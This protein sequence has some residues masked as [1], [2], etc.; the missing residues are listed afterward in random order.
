MVILL[1]SAGISEILWM[2]QFLLANSFLKIMDNTSHN[3]NILKGY[4]MLFYFA[5]SMI[6]HEPSEEC[7]VDFW[8]KGILKNLP[9]SSANPNFVKAAS[10][11]RDSFKDKI[12]FGKLLHEDFLR[13]F[14][15][16]TSALAPAYESLY[17]KNIFQS[18]D[19]LSA[20]VT[21][22]YNSYG[23]ESKFKG[24]IEDDHLG[25]ELL[26]LTLLIDKYLVLDD[27][28]CR[29]E[30][31]REIHRFINQHI[32]SWVPEWNKKIQ[33]HANTLS[34]KGIGNLIL[35]CTE[36]VFGFLDQE[37]SATIPTD[38]LKN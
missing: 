12:G 34:F 22:F 6:M 26:F 35:A 30:M 17:N 31:R 1:K 21:E 24:R 29:G 10:Q 32:L 3:N 9:V 11:L 14:A 36:D 8:E 5:G 23:W 15:R 33:N 25:V 37:S 7:I 2:Y 16:Q 13:L 19:H 27:K 20:S 4:N 18:T 28:A 38:Y